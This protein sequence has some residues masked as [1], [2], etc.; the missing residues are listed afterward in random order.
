ML[1]KGVPSR[2]IAH[3]L[4]VPAQYVYTIK[5][6]DAKDSGRTNATPA[7]PIPVPTK[8]GK[9]R[10]R[11]PKKRVE[12][13]LEGAPQPAEKGQIYFVPPRDNTLPFGIEA[14]PPQPGIFNLIVHK[15]RQWLMK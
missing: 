1:A 8:S 13:V 9:P 3:K 10:G 4:G 2:E 14:S 7:L 11:P 5:F 6:K 15:I 12:P